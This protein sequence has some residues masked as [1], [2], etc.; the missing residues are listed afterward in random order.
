MGVDAVAILRPKDPTKIRRHVDPDQPGTLLCPL[1]DGSLLF[2]SFVRFAAIEAEPTIIRDWLIQTFGADLGAV[3]DDP[4][5]VLVYPDIC[6]PRSQSYDAIVAEIEAAA[7]WVPLHATAAAVEHAERH[8]AAREAA[9]AA[10]GDAQRGLLAKIQGMMAR[11]V[12]PDS[13]EAGSLVAD[14]EALT[15]MTFDV[16]ALL[17]MACVL[18][19]R[20]TKLRVARGQSNDVV[21][22]PDRSTIVFTVMAADVDDL[23]WRLAEEYASWITEHEDPRGVPMFGAQHLDRV[24]G[25]KSYAAALRA[26]G[27]AV[28][29]LIPKGSAARNVERNAMLHAIIGP[30]TSTSKKKKAPPA[31]KKKAPAP[32]K[33][34]RAAKKKK[35][36]STRGDR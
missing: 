23:S 30:P 19:K 11:N 21:E 31:K 33:K 2:H 26:L 12:S 8:R 25:A 32:R 10:A 29:F 9:A 35:R 17:D 7:V 1:A 16:D 5:G 22:L 3:H 36:V 24:R 6:E 15:G 28:T 34:V 13:A 27:D 18:V 14:L 20:Q 4:R